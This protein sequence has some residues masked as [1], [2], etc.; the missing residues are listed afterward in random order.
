MKK[1]F[2]KE[3]EKKRKRVERFLNKF[4]NLRKVPEPLRSS[5]RYTI[6][7]GGK[8]LRP[9]LVLESYEITGKDIEDEIMPPACAVEMVHTF[10]LIH[11]D[12]PAIDNDDFRRGKPTL[13]KIFGEDIA[14][15]AGDALFIYGIETFLKSEAAPKR[16]LEAL[17]VFS[18]ALGGEGVIAG[19]VL[20]IKGVGKKPN[21][22][23]LK[24]V[25]MLKTAS[26]I[27]VCLEIGAIIAGVKER[28]REIFKKAG[29]EMGLAFQIQDDIL[30][31]T[32]DEKKVGKKLRKDADK[33]TYPKLFGVERSKEIAQK[34]V[35]NAKK[36]LNLLPYNTDFLQDICDFIIERK[37]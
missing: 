25:H 30:D 33:M 29:R 17:K 6:K 2:K 34:H 14:I 8:R 24:K 32:G 36:L 5:M 10:T 1:D 4:L 15:L 7:A 16:V 21:R 3:F 37:W 13:H 28:E 20:D 27:S 19:E 22:R 26:L 18:K 9:I 11:D 23:Y 35:N 31:I 12:L